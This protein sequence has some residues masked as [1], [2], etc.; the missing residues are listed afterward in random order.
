MVNAV[1][2]PPSAPELPPL[3]AL[4]TFEVA[5]RHLSFTRAAA[6]LHVTQTAVSHQVR[7]L[8][9]QLGTALFRRLPRRIA[10]TRDGQAWA[11]ELTEI[12]SRLADVNRRLRGRARAD[13]PMVSVSVVPSFAARWLVPRLGRFFARHRGFDVH[14]SPTEHLVDF[15]VEAVDVGIRWGGGQYPGLVVDKLA[16]DALVVVCAPSLP[17]RRRLGAPADLARHVL[18][19]DDARDAWPRWFAAQGVPGIE[20]TRGPVLTDSSML[21]EAAV[22]GQGVALARWSLAVDDVHA[23]RLVLPFPRVRPMATDNSYFLVS[24]REN[25]SRPAVRAFRDWVLAEAR[26][27][28]PPRMSGI[29]ASPGLRRPRNR[30]P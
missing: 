19:S 20:T 10:L 23:G 25:L 14:L 16:D 15:A 28:P 21:V 7:L 5:A 22:R 3:T 18:L 2:A 9:T 27:L 1:K 12:F 29:M 17:A 4:R 26:H 6:E 24:P 30:L 8:E 13:R 11:R